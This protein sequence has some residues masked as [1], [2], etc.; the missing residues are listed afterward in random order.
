MTKLLR[1]MIDMGWMTYQCESVKFKFALP[2]T[3]RLQILK[4]FIIMIVGFETLN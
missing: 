3:G 2:G 1:Y 4:K